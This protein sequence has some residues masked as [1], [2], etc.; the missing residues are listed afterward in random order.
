[1]ITIAVLAVLAAIAAPSFADMLERNRIKQAAETI[2]ADIEWARTESIK[3]SCNVE[4]EFTTG[5]NWQYTVTPCE[6][7]VKTY[8]TTSSSIS[9]AESTFTDDTITLSSTRGLANLGFLTVE[10][11]NY[12]LRISLVNGRQLVVCSPGT[13]IGGYSPC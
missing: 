7:S 5:V 6:S 3:E 8:S 13:V 4:V 11:E 1:M 9:L 12:A 2:V 10:S